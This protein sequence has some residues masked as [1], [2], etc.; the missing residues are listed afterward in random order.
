[1]TTQPP[2]RRVRIF[3]PGDVMSLLRFEIKQAGS[4][5]AWAKKAGVSRPILNKILNGRKPIAPS[6]IRALGL[7]IA[8]MSDDG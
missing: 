4:Q 7:R 3:E 8:I 5:M 6:I 2:L 1:V